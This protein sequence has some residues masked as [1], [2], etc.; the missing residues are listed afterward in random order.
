MHDALLPTADGGHIELL[1]ILHLIYLLKVTASCIHVL[2]LFVNVHRFKICKGHTSE[3]KLIIG[4]TKLLLHVK[5][6]FLQ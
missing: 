6:Y 3:F 1:S 5:Y 2:V 4:S